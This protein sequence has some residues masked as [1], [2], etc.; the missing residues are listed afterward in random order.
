M[1]SG[2]VVPCHKHPQT[3]DVTA[4]CPPRFC[5]AAGLSHSCSQA[6][7]LGRLGAR[8]GSPRP[9]RAPRAHLRGFSLQPRSLHFF[10]VFGGP[11]GREQ[12][13]LHG[14]W[15][16]SLLLAPPG[17][18]GQR[19][20]DTLALSLAGEW[21]SCGTRADRMGDSVFAFEKY[22]GHKLGAG[23]QNAVRNLYLSVA[24]AL[25]SGFAGGKQCLPEAP[26]YQPWACPS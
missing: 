8:R 19:Q 21:H 22:R 25:S 5:G 10:R 20:V 17:Q 13:L 11:R 4:G 2:Y 23:A 3:Q 1:L 24:L 14:T 9:A 26:G 18:V 6:A 15:P 16:L 12:R 7:R